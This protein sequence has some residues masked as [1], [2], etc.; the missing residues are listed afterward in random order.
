MAERTIA[1]LVERLEA[2]KVWHMPVNDYDDLAR[3]P[4]VAHNGSLMTMPG[5]TGSPI[6]LLNHPNRFDGE[7]AEARLVPQ[8][9]GAQTAEILAELG[10]DE[11]RIRRLEADGVIKTHAS[12]APA[13][14][15]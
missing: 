13:G 15:A 2:H 6:T 14:K 3:D 4:Q 11:A 10:Y 7:A 8:P 9:L 1:D 5:A 12:E